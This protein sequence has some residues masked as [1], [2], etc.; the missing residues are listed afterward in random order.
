MESQINGSL[1][2]SFCIILTALAP[3][4][5]KIRQRTV[6]GWSREK[7]YCNERKGKK[8]MK[9]APWSWMQI[10]VGI[11]FNQ[12]WGTKE[13][14]TSVKPVSERRKIKVLW[15]IHIENGIRRIGTYEIEWRRKSGRQN[16]SHQ[17]SG[18]TFQVLIG[19]TPGINFGSLGNED[20]SNCKKAF[21]THLLYR[22]ILDRFSDHAS[23]HPK[24]AEPVWRF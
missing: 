16:I 11:I 24:Y 22:G 20:N 13:Q 9:M 5:R 15:V 21:Q 3:S 18:R 14:N 12:H 23:P 4:V 7:C 6:G 10:V 2:P 8:L 1:L 17:V 19:P